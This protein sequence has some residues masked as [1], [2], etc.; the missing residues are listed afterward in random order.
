MPDADDVQ[1]DMARTHDP[2]RP[3][4]QVEP[5]QSGQAEIAM[6]GS[7]VGLMDLSRQREDQAEGVLGNRVLTVRR[8]VADHDSTRLAGSQ[9]DV[10][11]TSRTRGDEAQR[12]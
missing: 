6:D 3:S 4:L 11:V 9:I 8:D 1:A 7:G 10:V 5:S 12:R 2:E